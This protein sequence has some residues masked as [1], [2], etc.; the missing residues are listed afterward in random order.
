[1]QKDDFTALADIEDRGV[2]SVAP[3]GSL[4]GRSDFL[5]APVT[6]QSAF[7][8]VWSLALVPQP[9]FLMGAFLVGTHA[10]ELNSRVILNLD[11]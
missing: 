1:M 2:S 3:C 6:W 8:G 11:P 9:P 5:L 10:A 7:P 4:E